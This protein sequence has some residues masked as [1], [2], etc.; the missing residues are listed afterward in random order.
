MAD[1]RYPRLGERVELAVREADLAGGDPDSNRLQVFPS[2]VLGG[3]EEVLELAAPLQRGRFRFPRPEAE[4]EVRF[5]RDGRWFASHARVEANLLAPPE[6]VRVRLG[7]PSPFYRRAA[8]RWPLHLPVEVLP[9]P[10]A[11]QQAVRMGLSGERLRVVPRPVAG[12]RWQGTTVDV[13]VG[14]LFC[15][16]RLRGRDDAA[17][18]SGPGEAPHL[19]T[20]ETYRLLLDLRARE[21]SRR[22]AG[23]GAGEREEAEAGAG[24]LDLAGRL[25][26]VA[27]SPQEPGLWEAAFAFLEVSLADEQAIMRRIFAEQRRL[28]RQGLI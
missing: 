27:A 18:G 20:G 13:S 1:L 24:V 7:P 23:R 21:P 11:V 10:P 16:L 12:P 3:E 14:G 6:R 26:R 15:R 2:L 28:R 9:L 22:R 8:V 4:V 25:V 17:A 5:G 19:V